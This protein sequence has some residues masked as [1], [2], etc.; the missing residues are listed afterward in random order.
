MWENRTKAKNREKDVVSCR[1]N[2]YR[3]E[4]IYCLPLHETKINNGSPN[5]AIQIHFTGSGIELM[6][7]GGA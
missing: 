6:Q 1:E 4:K 7:T 5:I 3:I 2:V